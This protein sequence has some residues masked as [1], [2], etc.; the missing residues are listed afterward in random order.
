MASSQGTPKN[1][2]PIV[3]ATLSKYVPA[4]VSTDVELK[5][6]ENGPLDENPLHKYSP[7]NPFSPRVREMESNPSPL[8][9][10]SQWGM[11]GSEDKEEVKKI[12]IVGGGMSGF[13]AYWA[14]RKTR[15][16]VDLFEATDDFASLTKPILGGM[17]PNDV[18]I[19][20][21]FLNCFAHTS[22]NLMKL[23]Q[24]LKI[25]F[26]STPFNFTVSKE[27]NIQHCRIEYL[28]HRMNTTSWKTWLEPSTWKL[29]YEIWKFHLFSMDLLGTRRRGPEDNYRTLIEGGICIQ[30]TVGRYLD[31]AGYSENFMSKYLFPLAQIVWNIESPGDLRELPIQRFVAFLWTAGVFGISP[32]IKI[33]R[34]DGD[35]AERLK[36][37]ILAQKNNKT[38]HMNSRVESV[39]VRPDKGH[40]LLH[41]TLSGDRMLFYDY[42][43]FAVPP[44]EAL[45][46]LGDEVTDGEREILGNFQSTRVHAWLHSDNRL[47]PNGQVS[48]YINW[49]MFG[50]DVPQMPCIT[51]RL[52]AFNDRTCATSPLYV[53]LN[54]MIR[55]A[56]KAT[57]AEWTYSRP[58]INARSLNARQHLANIQNV[59]NRHLMFCG[60]WDGYGLHEDSVRSAFWLATRYFDAKLSFDFT[61]SSVTYPSAPPR[62]VG[63]LSLRAFLYLLG[64][65]I[66]I[67]KSIVAGVNSL[68]TSFGAG[69]AFMPT[70][71]PYV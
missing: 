9:P 10:M 41:L 62:T 27:R 46:L 65:L 23:C 28:S 51:Y 42:I 7:N 37:R 68:L 22:P 31:D 36:R 49:A 57:V 52:N 48:S 53:T 26:I 56:L 4:C 15:Y 39:V 29:Y 14:L 17:P 20:R 54:P 55:P 35:A 69:M 6:I 16:H 13:A 40:R 61:D 21:S 1:E 19:D 66:W 44:E 71:L 64:M 2:T 33:L 30:W 50:D 18:K 3:K 25:P 12:A 43:I 47:V 24:Y 60:S 34:P 63:E 38:I 67:W 8:S 11:P 32:T 70:F 59:T 5:H 45:R 58:V